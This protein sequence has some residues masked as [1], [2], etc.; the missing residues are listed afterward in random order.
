MQN[1]IAN[2]EACLFVATK[3]VALKEL[4]KATGVSEAEVSAAI[5]ELTQLRNVES[6]GIH[7]I[8]LDGTVQLVSSPACSETVGRIAKDELAPELTRPSL[9]A[10]TIIAYRGPVTKPEIEAIRGVNCSLIL[11]NLLMRGLIE[12]KDDAKRM[13]AVYTLSADALRFLGLHA[14][15]ELP[16]YTTLHANAHID[17]L[18]VAVM[19]SS[20][21]GEGMAETP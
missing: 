13:Q 16:D 7:I 12:E 20:S 18:L 8:S 15:E 19:T 3:P 5:A 14:K 17:K 1:V 6:S 4:V 21:V 2:V 10:L 9:E 11:R